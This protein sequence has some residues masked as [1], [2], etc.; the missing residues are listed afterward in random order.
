V[1]ERDLARVAG[2]DVQ[3]GR[4]DRGDD[5]EG[6]GAQ[7]RRPEL[8]RQRDEHEHDDDQEGSAAHQTRSTGRTP[9]SP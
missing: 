6:R 3:P 4:A 2:Q 9:N 8:E 1:P 7:R 5:D